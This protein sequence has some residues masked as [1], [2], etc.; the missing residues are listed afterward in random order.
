MCGCAV[1]NE[2]FYVKHLC[3]E[4]ELVS[5]CE[6]LFW[7]GKCWNLGCDGIFKLLKVCII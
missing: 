6:K 1:L 7:C 5:G 3:S 2:L 4:S